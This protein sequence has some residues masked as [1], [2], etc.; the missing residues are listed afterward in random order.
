MI[1]RRRTFLSAMASGVALGVAGP[2]WA[3][4]ERI[5][6]FWWGGNDR[7]KRTESAV[8][9]FKAGNPDL[10]VDTEFAGWD[11]YWTRLATQVAGRNA[12]DL[13]QMDPL[14]MREY[15]RRGSIA[16]LDKYVGDLLDIETF[17]K[18]NLESCSVDGSLY[19]VN[20]GVNA[21]G[22]V[23]DAGAWQEVGVLP[24]SFGT[25]W[26]ELM[27]KTK[28]FAAA[29]KKSGFYAI[30]DGSGT[31]N[32]FE[33][34]LRSQ[35]AQ[36]YTDDGKL[37][38]DQGLL[39]AWF[40]YWATMRAAGGCVTPD[41]QALSKNEVASQPLTLGHAA[42]DFCHSNEFLSFCELRKAPLSL[43]GIP[44]SAA[45]ERS[46]YLK[47]SQMFSVSGG[48]KNPDAA[49]KLINFLV[50]NPEGVKFL[51]V[52][53]GVP[54]SPIMRHLLMPSL[55]DNERATVEFISN[56]EPYLGDIPPAPPSGGGEVSTLLLRIS[57]EIGFGGS[58]PEQGAASY[59]EEANAV[60]T[61]R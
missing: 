56:L 28:A 47:P 5:R 50:A 23:V 33:I 49:V 9:A 45:A 6:M 8:D 19:G 1:I 55:N 36:L 25:T 42:A 54:A 41:I 16:Q 20:S 60:L 32:I 17:G 35:G 26:T 48:S 4:S 29:N 22:L 30:A 38:F 57:Q 58:T 18:A 12:P 34:W 3:A 44:I 53:R 24:P 7:A 43:T 10:Q 52:E 61:R 39:T 15:A 11:G 13:I 2:S 59:F 21:F 14:Y 37:G 40:Q 46:N 51:G 31:E 27:E